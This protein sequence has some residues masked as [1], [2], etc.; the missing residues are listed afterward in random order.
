TL[1]G[2]IR[3]LESSPWRALSVAACALGMGAKEV[4]VAAPIVV[5]LYDRSFV[6]ESWLHVWR[7]RWRLHVSLGATWVVLAGLMATSRLEGRGVGFS[8]AISWTDY[9]LTQ[10]HAV[11]LYLRLAIWPWPLIFDYGWAYERNVLR[12]A[13]Q[14]VACAAVI[15]GSILI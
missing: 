15:V 7:S 2:F 1:Y 3:G 9:A 10:S 6:A 12:A 14:I 4:M 5:L 11:L 13:P 8:D